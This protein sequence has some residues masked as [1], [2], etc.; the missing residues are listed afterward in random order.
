MKGVIK[1]SLL[2][3]AL[4]AASAAHAGITLQAMSTFG[5]GDGWLAPNEGGYAYLSN[6]SLERGLAY[7]KATGNLVL[8]S[9][10][11]LGN[12]IRVLSGTTGSETGG[13]GGNGYL[14]QGTGIISGGTFTTNMAAADDDGNVYVANLTTN[15]GTSALKVYKWAGEGAAAPTV[16][17]SSTISGF[18]GTPRLGD[19]FDAMGGAANLRLALGASGVNGYAAIDAAGVG[20]AVTGITSTNAGDFRLGI[21]FGDTNTDVFGK[22]TGANAGAAPLRY[23]SAG[24]LLKSLTLT[25]GGEMAMD[26]AVIDGYKMLAT[27]DANS[28][29]VRLYEILG[30]G[31]GM[32]AVLRTSLTNTSGTLTAN[33][34][35]VGQ[36]R[37]GAI[38][39]N[40]ATLYAMSTNQGIQAFNVVVPEPSSIAAVGFGVVALLRRRMKKS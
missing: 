2:A 25:S 3:M 22:Q 23:T 26:Y 36:V 6:G 17:F 27:V 31:S 33:G 29:M 39:G 4:A 24:S 7:N 8:V 37:W 19:S 32:T 12:G 15:V 11:T 35:A 20:S 34:N 21:T 30:S 16:F 5:G 10:S 28:S 38:N 18:T 9:R 1:G 40:K 14:N 13:F